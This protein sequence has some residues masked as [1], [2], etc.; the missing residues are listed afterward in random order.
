MANGKEEKAI[1]R[2]FNIITDDDWLEMDAEAKREMRTRRLLVRHTN[3]PSWRADVREHYQN[4]C[5]EN[6]TGAVRL[7]TPEGYNTSSTVLIWFACE[8][9]AVAFKLNHNDQIVP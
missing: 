3:R 6:C 4:W 8:A 7:T 5:I 2:S 9:D 1:V